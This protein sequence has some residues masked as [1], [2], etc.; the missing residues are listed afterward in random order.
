MLSMNDKEGIWDQVENGVSPS[1]A[2]SW[3]NERAPLLETSKRKNKEDPN[4]DSFRVEAPNPKNKK[5]ERRPIRTLTY[6]NDSHISVLCQ[7]YGSVWP[8]VL[9][10]CLLNVLITYVVFLLKHSFHID[11]CFA[12][13]NGHSFMAIMVSF[14]VVT[15]ASITYNRFMEA[16]E[17]LSVCYRTCRELVQCACVLTLL[18]EGPGAKKWRSDVAYRTILL[19]RVTMAAIEYRT[20]NV[21]TWEVLPTDDQANLEVLSPVSASPTEAN[22]RNSPVFKDETTKEGR[23][24]SSTHIPVT[25]QM[26]RMSQFSHGVRTHQDENLRAPIILAMNLRETILLQRRENEYFE[27]EMHVN[28]ELKILG[29][30]AEFLV[31][32]HGLKKLITTPFPFPLVQM[33]RT[34]LFFWVF[35]LPLVLV[36][37]MGEDEA[38]HVMVIIFFITYGFLG[39][40]YVSIELDDP[41]GDDPNDFDNKG[42][43]L[44]VY[45]DIYIAIYKMDGSKA[46]QQLRD[47]VVAEERSGS[48]LRRARKRASLEKTVAAPSKP[49][50]MAD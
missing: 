15:R 19:L 43:S 20:S 21:H 8:N 3:M 37:E 39:L 45:E 33:T 12:S 30:V 36:A 10:F 34:F 2:S 17:Y 22:G 48:P 40:E 4:H 25:S 23:R 26:Q 29:F 5:L 18:E 46:A 13:G 44:L 9:K 7:M 1:A 35:T 14:L 32:F 41:F 16:R 42:M 38:V 50:I 11:I 27:K 49:N 47:K 6:D 31:A 24:R 28:E